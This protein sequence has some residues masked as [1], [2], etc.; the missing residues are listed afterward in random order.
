MVPVRS[1]ALHSHGSILIGSCSQAFRRPNPLAQITILDLEFPKRKVGPRGDPVMI[2]GPILV[3]G[4][5]VGPTQRLILGQGTALGSIQEPNLD[6]GTT[7]GP[8]QGTILGPKTVLGSIQGLI[9]GPKT[10]GIDPRADPGP[11]G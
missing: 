11:K 6:P 10:P 1:C 9:P 8:I 5:A 4:A 3:L 2:Q 7:P